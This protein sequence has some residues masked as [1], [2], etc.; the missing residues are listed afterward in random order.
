MHSFSP[1][2]ISFLSLSYSSLGLPTPS[3]FTQESDDDEDA[4]IDDDTPAKGDDA[5]GDSAEIDD[6]DTEYPTLSSPTKYFIF[7]VFFIV[8]PVGAGVFFYGGGK[9]RWRKWRASKG[10]EKVEVA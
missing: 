5:E 2:P 1:P 7:L 4:E 6:L 9:E 8:L 10:Y 3:P